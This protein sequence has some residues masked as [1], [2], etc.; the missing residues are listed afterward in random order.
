MDKSTKIEWAGWSNVPLP[1]LTKKDIC[2]NRTRGTC[3]DIGCKCMLYGSEP[4]ND[5]EAW[6]ICRAVKLTVEVIDG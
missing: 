3:N 5:R 4:D 2:S 1:E 6:E